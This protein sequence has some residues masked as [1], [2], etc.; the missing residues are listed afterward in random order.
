MC[1][2]KDETRCSIIY[3]NAVYKDNENLKLVEGG[4]QFLFNVAHF[5]GKTDWIVYTIAGEV[6]FYTDIHDGVER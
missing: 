6:K 2:N 4:T 5:L 3:E 1:A